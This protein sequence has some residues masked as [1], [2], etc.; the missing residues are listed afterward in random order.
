MRHLPLL[1]GIASAVIGLVVEGGSLSCGCDCG[2]TGLSQADF[3]WANFASCTAGF[4]VSGNGLTVL[5]PIPPGFFLD[6]YG[7]IDLSFN[8]F[9]AVPPGAFQGVSFSVYARNEPALLDLSHNSLASVDPAAFQGLSCP[10]VCALDLSHNTLTYLPDEVFAGLALYSLDLSHNQVS[11]VA[12][13]TFGGAT[14]SF[15]LDLSVNSLSTLFPGAFFNVPLA[16]LSLAYNNLTSL[17]A[18]VFTG[19]VFA[20]NN[21]GLPSVNLSHN[22]LGT[23]EAGT[24]THTH[25]HV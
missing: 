2:A 17:Q 24:Y 22:E 4:N 9:T 16:S 11:G 14:G 19:A 13:G 6:L 1:V 15:I 23:L 12:S 25:S 7:V 10:Q 5:P 8:A 20:G 21:G 3:Q 18:G